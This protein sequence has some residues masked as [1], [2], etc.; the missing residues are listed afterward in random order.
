MRVERG[1]EKDGADESP[2]W[3]VGEARRQEEH[4]HEGSEEQAKS[5]S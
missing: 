1:E 4:T 5:V 2:S 3:V